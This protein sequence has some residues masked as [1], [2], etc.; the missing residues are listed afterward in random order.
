M[1]L[2]NSRHART[3]HLPSTRQRNDGH[4]ENQSEASGFPAF[5]SPVI[6]PTHFMK[7]IS[8]SAAVALAVAAFCATPFLNPQAA[9]AKPS[10]KSSAGKPVGTWGRTT[11]SSTY[12]RIRPGTQTPIVA[13]VPKGTQL[14]VWGTFN[15]WYRVETTDHKFGWIYNNLVNVPRADKLIELSHA[16]A[17][18]ASDRTGNQVMYGDAATLKKY[19][20]K[21]KAPG[22]KAGLAK[23][24]VVLAGKT[25]AKPAVKV[26][27]AKPAPK[28]VVARTGAPHNGVP[29][30]PREVSI[31]T[32]ETPT[33]NAKPV[34][35]TVVTP[36]VKSVPQ[37]KPTTLASRKGAPRQAGSTPKAPVPLE[38]TTVEPMSPSKLPQISAED[39]MAARKAYIQRQQ[40]SSRKQ[41]RPRATK[42]S[43]GSTIKTAPAAKPVK[44][45]KGKFQPTSV[46]QIE[47]ELDALNLTPEQQAEVVGD[48]YYIASAK[49]AP[50]KAAPS[51]GGSPRDYA[52]SQKGKANS[53]M[54]QKALSY[55]G[56]PYIRG[57][58][59]PSRGFDCSGLVYYLLRSRGYNPPRTAAGYAKY[60]KAVAKKDLKPGDLVLF[61]NTYKR[62]ISHI[63]IYIGNNNFVHAA[64][65][66]SGVKTD[67]LGSSYYSKKYWGAR[68]VP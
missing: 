18:Q 10:A 61:A 47:A 42:S 20:A 23:Q 44:Q 6:F 12:I 46:Q 43:P 25:P 8:Q 31:V 53:A 54:A 40:L 2:Q 15:G 9:Q 28:P 13:K 45:V 50:S 56:K 48:A 14:M 3:L 36:V 19:Y 7:H 63:G 5:G 57:A 1:H 22:A 51:R 59:S 11:G 24:G 52:K 34:E 39:I 21:H 17:R 32:A 62:G 65:K 30:M 16:K 41:T 38:A 37:S 55:R 66:R 58:S 29:E 67:S 4:H 68:R 26:V 64:N 60:G 27:A 33:D 35:A 49:K